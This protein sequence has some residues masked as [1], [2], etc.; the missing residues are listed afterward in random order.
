[1]KDFPSCFGQSVIQVES[2][3]TTAKSGAQNTVTCVYQYKSKSITGFITVTWIKHLMGQGLTVGIQNSTKAP[4]CRADIKT[5]LFSKR[6][7]FKNLVSDSEPVDIFWDLSSAQFGSG[8]EPLQGFYL[9]ILVNQELRLLLG[10]QTNEAYKKIYSSSTPCVGSRAI[11]VARE[12]HIIFGKRLYNSKARFCDEGDVHDVR[13][14]YDP[15]D[16]YDHC[17]A[18]CIDDK[19]MIQVARLKWNFRG[20]DT[21]T[22]DGLLIQVYWDVHRWL[23]QSVVGNAVFLF[24]SGDPKHKTSAASGFS[25]VLCAW[26]SE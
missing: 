4:L 7:G 15:D 14:E 9:A 12:E 18:I 5:W 6:K 10:D 22:V 24:R 25:L 19:T 8:P 17:L 21:I 2:S 20:N 11:F 26:K 1:M 16:S 23:Y 3:T 13:I